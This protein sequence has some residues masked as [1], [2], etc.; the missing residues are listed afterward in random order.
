MFSKIACFFGFHAFEVKASTVSYMQK[1]CCKHC[2]KT[3]LLAK[4]PDGTVVVW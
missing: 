1:R 2:P 3:Q 4:A